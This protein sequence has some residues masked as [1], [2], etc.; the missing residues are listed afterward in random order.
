MRKKQRV[1]GE[2]RNIGDAGWMV[3]GSPEKKVVEVNGGSPVK[4][5][6]GG[7]TARKRTNMDR[8]ITP[9]KI[10]RQSPVKKIPLNDLKQSPAKKMPLNDL[11]AKDTEE[12]PV[13]RRKSLRSS[14]R[15]TLASLESEQASESPAVRIFTGA[16]DIAQPQPVEEE[17]AT[18]ACQTSS[19]P[20]LVISEVTPTIKS[21]VE[22]VPAQEPPEI[23]SSAITEAAQLEPSDAVE[24]F[25]QE[26]TSKDVQ[27]GLIE[28]DEPLSTGVS[29]PLDE[30]S[31]KL[32]EE[33]EQRSTQEDTPVEL[34][35]NAEMSSSVTDD[36]QSVQLTRD[37]EQIS[38][39]ES[40]SEELMNE[41]EASSSHLLE[42]EHSSDVR[43]FAMSSK[44][45]SEIEGPADLRKAGEQEPTVLKSVERADSSEPPPSK[46]PV[47]PKSR[48]RT[49]QRRGT[50][51]STRTTRASSAQIEDQT[52]QEAAM[53]ENMPA[54]SSKRSASPKKFSPKKKPQPRAS[55]SQPYELPPEAPE[56]GTSPSLSS[57]R[58]ASPKKVSPKKQAQS[59]PQKMGNHL[60]SE[61]MP[62]L[63]QDE[64]PEQ[65][66]ENASTLEEVRAVPSKEDKTIS[67]EEVPEE[68]IRSNTKLESTEV[69]IQIPNTDNPNDTSPATQRLSA[70]EPNMEVLQ[71]PMQTLEN[72]K[73]ESAIPDNARDE[74]QPT[75]ESAH[76]TQSELV[77]DSEHSIAEP[78]DVASELPESSV[79]TS[80]SSDSDGTTVHA[81]EVLEPIEVSLSNPESQREHSPSEPIEELPE[82]STPD[83]TTTE[84]VEAISENAPPATYDHDDTDMLRN[85]LTRVKANKAAKAEKATPKRKRSLPHSPLRIPLGDA[86]ADDANLSPTSPKDKDEFDVSLPTGSPAKRRKR[87]EHT[88]EEDV[89][90]PRSIRRSGRTRLPVKT[91]IAAPSFI[92]VRRLGQEGGDN[93]ITVQRKSAEKELAALTRINTRKNKAGAVAP[94]DVLA[95]KAEEKDDPASRQRALKEVFDE[96]E[97]MQSK[98]KKG[99]SVV[100]A[101]E[102]AQYQTADGKK[103]A[104]VDKP[105]PPAEPEKEKETEVANNEEK[106][107]SSV[108]R[109]GSKIALGMAVNGTPAPKRK[110][111]GRS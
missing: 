42:F 62:T 23:E 29:L 37:S 15:L 24:G 79:V 48:K 74:P 73:L 20:Q 61:A 100:W 35:R 84:L 81:L 43:D 92:P 12:K 41:T 59:L 109:I 7:R 3:A 77:A 101:E 40:S 65:V 16:V 110:K 28:E 104:V 1:L 105:P 50:R 21:T 107:K 97:K 60:L 83:P 91:P 34:I 14:T 4:S 53:V 64:S 86:D 8:V 99:K 49:P 94:A 47:T 66:E 9:R 85:F 108:P 18:A 25:K 78:F 93:T 88:A 33:L 30:Q 89:T 72:P 38:A 111:R 87:N 102:L 11:E 82:T 103:V 44:G 27:E 55:L 95:K 6:G 71:N 26:A 13:R 32:S 70:E 10:T 67:P 36:E 98:G 54:S 75:K 39:P 31:V 45:E 58:L 80:P 96:K 106:K 17:T 57:Y 56:L 90:E 19:D 52:V 69:D 5:H 76:E 22:D 46:I 68:A 2:K 63:P 51:R